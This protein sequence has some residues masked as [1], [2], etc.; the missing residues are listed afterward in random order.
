MYCQ[1]RTFKMAEGL[2]RQNIVEILKCLPRT[3]CRPCGSTTCMVFATRVAKGVKGAEDC[4]EI[5][6]RAQKNLDDYMGGFRFD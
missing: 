1:L 6:A 3:N 5:E 2:P 4:P